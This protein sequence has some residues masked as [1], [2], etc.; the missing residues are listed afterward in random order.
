MRT[1]TL[2]ARAAA[3]VSTL[4]SLSALAQSVPPA[5]PVQGRLFDTESTPINTPLPV[6][7]TLYAEEAGTTQ[8]WQETQT[9]NFEQGYFTAYLG[10]AT[11]LDVSVF[12][13]QP[14][15]Y[16]GIAVNGDP[17]MERVALSTVP[18]AAFAQH[19]L[20]ADTA[21]SATSAET[22]RVADMLGN[23]SANDLLAA[24]SSTDW[25]QITNVPGDIL[26]GDGDT[27]ALLTCFPG[28]IPK[29]N[30]TNWICADDQFNVYTA[31]NPIMVD[32]SNVFSLADN[33]VTSAHVADGDLVD[34]DI[35][36]VAGIQP[37]K[38]A[39]TAATL[40]GSQ[41]FDNNTLVIDAN[42]HRVGMGV[43]SPVNKLDVSGDIGVTG[44]FKYVLPVLRR[45]N[46]T[47]AGF[48]LSY[49]EH[50]TYDPMTRQSGGYAYV[51]GG[52]ANYSNYLMADLHLPQ[53]AAI[54][55][56]TC[57]YYD[58]SSTVDLSATVYFYH[59]GLTDTSATLALSFLMTT[60]GTSANVVQEASSALGQ[61]LVVDNL[62][63]A[64]YLRVL[65]S[66]G[67]DTSS[68]A[69]FY[70]CS[71]DYLVTTL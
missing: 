67:S 28:Y 1:R 15:V 23:Y 40:S 36:M 9:L 10:Q 50:A 18:Y 43:P 68:A 14:T 8:L 70:G 16:L 21:Q 56:V 46:V 63:R 64:Y 49:S 38:I 51:L 30:G 53:D 31:A 58:N 47:P 34:Q 66:T 55:R 17:E 27:L 59:K 20:A 32:D 69:R 6:V 29:W 33:G 4:V 24:A 26:D 2:P 5:V 41:S 48:T 25:S 3:A 62:N 7:F 44:S 54:T 61:P 45:Y 65:W 52:T 11:P 39:G 22:A 35:S 13:R 60:A 57:R 37:S 19:A 42:N 12:S 71:V